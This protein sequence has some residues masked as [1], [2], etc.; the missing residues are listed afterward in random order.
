MTDDQRQQIQRLLRD[1]QIRIT[2]TAVGI[3]KQPHDEELQE[4]FNRLL[5][6]RKNLETILHDGIVIPY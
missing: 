3:G 6:Q 1:L 4:R 2:E 5:D